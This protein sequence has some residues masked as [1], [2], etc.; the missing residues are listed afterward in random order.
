MPVNYIDDDLEELVEVYAQKY[1]DQWSLKKFNRYMHFHNTRVETFLAN[2]MLALPKKRV[3]L[4]KEIWLN[5]LLNKESKDERDN[6]VSNVFQHFSYIALKDNKTNFW[7]LWE[8]MFEWY[9]Q[10]DSSILLS[11]LM[12]H[13]EIM[14]YDLLNDWE[15]LE[16]AKIH[17]SKLLIALKADCNNLLPNL[18]CRMG[19]KELLPDSLRLVDINV[20]K[21]SSFNPQNFINW[22][23]AVEDLYDDPASREVIRNNPVLRSAYVEVLN[24]LISNGSAI[25]YIIRDYYI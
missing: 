7:Q 13:F 24:A 17:I 14:R 18:L 19:Y 4:I 22:Q 9:Q 20:L 21:Q 11:A 6:P 1:V 15:V 3:R 12:L 23:N 2:Y 25:A 8:I 16:G 10:H 5:S